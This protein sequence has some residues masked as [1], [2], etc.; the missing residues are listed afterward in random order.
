[1]TFPGRPDV[2]QAVAEPSQLQVCAVLR[3]WGIKLSW[4]VNLYVCMY[5]N[6]SISTYCLRLWEKEDTWSQFCVTAERNV[7][8]D[9]KVMHLKWLKSQNLCSSH[10][11]LMNSTS[12][13]QVLPFNSSFLSSFRLWLILAL[14]LFSISGLR[15]CQ[16]QIKQSLIT[17]SSMIHNLYSFFCLNSVVP[18]TLLIKQHTGSHQSTL[19]LTIF[20]H[21]RKIAKSDN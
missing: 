19:P 9:Y 1:M 15:I 12:F 5:L 2:S 6:I 20:W 16:Q 11:T 10:E 13:L 7:A 8:D 4:S 3:I 14:L 17:K 18:L 21:I